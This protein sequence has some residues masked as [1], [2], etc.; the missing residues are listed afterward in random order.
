MTSSNAPPNIFHSRLKK[1]GRNVGFY[2]TSA[3]S[4]SKIASKESRSK[5]R[6]CA[7]ANFTDARDFFSP[8]VTVL[9]VERYDHLCWRYRFFA[10][11]KML[12][13][14]LKFRQLA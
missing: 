4:K 12:S 10:R 6:A 2:P 13:I 7:A 9:P 1:Q 5:E 14:V 11:D 3:T 8:S